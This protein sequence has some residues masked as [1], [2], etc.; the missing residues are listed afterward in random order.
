MVI[1]RAGSLLL[2]DRREVDRFV[3]VHRLAAERLG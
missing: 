2:T 1:R 3:R